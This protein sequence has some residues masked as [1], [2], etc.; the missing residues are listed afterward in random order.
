VDLLQWLLQFQH[1]KLREHLLG[2][3]V[4][5]YY[6]LHDEQVLLVV[7]TELVYQFFYLQVELELWSN[8][9]NHVNYTQHITCN[10]R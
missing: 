5:C 10:C 4:H 7:D 9:G 2:Q 6:H 3:M 1:M 8:K